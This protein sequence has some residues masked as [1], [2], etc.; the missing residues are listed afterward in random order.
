M[1]LLGSAAM[2]LSFDVAA[3]AIGEH[4]D[5]HSHEHLAERLSIPGFVR[6]SRWVALHGGPRYL[7]L[8]EVATLATLTSGP[9]LQRLDHPSAWTTRIMPSYRGMRRGLCSVTAS[10]GLGLGGIC[11]LVR[12][13]PSASGAASLQAHLVDDALPRVT[14]QSGIGSA[15]LLQAAAAAPMTNEQRIRG[16]DVGMDWALLVTG[17]DERALGDL[18]N[19]PLGAAVLARHGCA[20]SS[21]AR[22]GLQYVASQDEL[23]RSG[24]TT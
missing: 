22:Y 6:A 19:G 10:F 9:Y 11:L 20:D 7:V 16:A 14:A 15:H 3:D 18:A 8:Y 23:A 2:L 24:P 5:W 1:P 12:L 21:H 4:D 17:Y 13:K